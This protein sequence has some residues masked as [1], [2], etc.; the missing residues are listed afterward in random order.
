MAQQPQLIIFSPGY[1]VNTEI[2]HDFHHIIMKKVQ[3]NNDQF[4]QYTRHN[5]PYPYDPTIEQK[6]LYD[7]DGIVYL[8]FGM[9]KAQILALQTKGI[10]D[11][12]VTDHGLRLNDITF[13]ITHNGEPRQLNVWK[14]V[15]A[16]NNN[17]TLYTPDL[18]RLLYTGHDIYEDQD[19]NQ[20]YTV[21]TGGD[22]L[23]KSKE[24]TLPQD[25]DRNAR[26]LHIN[27]LHSQATLGDSASKTLPDSKKYTKSRQN[28]KIHSWQYTKQLQ[29]NHNDTP[30]MSRFIS[31]YNISCGYGNRYKVTQ[32]WRLGNETHYYTADAN[33]DNNIT[34]TTAEINEILPEVLRKRL[35]IGD[36][37]DRIW[38][39]TCNFN[40]NGP[41]NIRSTL[42]KRD[43]LSLSF[44]KKRSGDHLQAL[45]AFRCGNNNNNNDQVIDIQN[46]TLV[47]SSDN[48][49]KQAIIS[50]NIND[51]TRIKEQRLQFNR[52]ENYVVT[53]DWVLLC[54]VLYLG[55][56]ALF[57]NKNTGTTF[58]FKSVPAVP[59]QNQPP[60]DLNDT[61]IQQQNIMLQGIG[62]L[63]GLVKK[64]F[65]Y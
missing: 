46:W 64:M 26:T 62:L 17:K 18:L 6:I 35:T 60:E 52:D 47:N 44:Q 23:L 39:K 20:Y 65:G 15:K 56:N 41:D 42:N 45:M 7:D 49:Y 43:A 16:L 54:Y 28:Y 9:T 51:L 2:N 14:C 24:F 27:I 29:F 34:T 3:L 48:D 8:F 36:L 10:H 19:I 11:Q 61:E 57:Q 50:G 13:N 12:G 63:S 38:N 58:K 31:N 33:N 21:D 32:T 59:E 4:I 30:V 40:K 5:T 37:D 55:E 25:G 1:W 22:I 53:Y